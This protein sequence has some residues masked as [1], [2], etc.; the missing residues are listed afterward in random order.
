M[1]DV[2]DTWKE[3]ELLP[4]TDLIKTGDVDIIMSAHVIN[5]ALSQQKGV[6]SSLSRATLMGQLRDTLGFRGVVISDDLQMQAIADHIKFEDAVRRAVLA[7]NDILIFANDKHP[8]PLIPE[9]VAALLNLEAH[10]NPEMLER[11]RKSYRKRQAAEEEALLGPLSAKRRWRQNHGPLRLEIAAA[12]GGTVGKGEVMVL[13]HCRRRIAALVSGTVGAALGAFVTAAAQ[14]GAELFDYPQTALNG[15]VSAQVSVPAEAC[16]QLCSTRSGCAGFDHSSE[17]ICRLFLIVGGATESV[18]HTAGTRSLLANYRP[19]LN[20]PVEP[21]Q[22]SPP[23]AEPAPPTAFMRFANRDLSR[24]ATETRGA[25]SIDQC[26]AMCRYAGGWCKAYTFDTWNEKCFMKEGAGQLEI[27]AR[28]TSGVSS[29]LGTPSLSS[30]EIRFERFNNKA[31]PGDRFRVLS[32]GSR[33]ACEGEC[34]SLN[35]CI[36]YSFTQSQGRC[37]LYEQP[38]EYSS[39]PGT[40]SG[41]KRQD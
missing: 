10:R 27:N 12:I 5:D 6:P 26:E 24:D 41:A 39:R 8:D 36:A 22:P 1:A 35:Q 40:H 9:K 28:A 11:I 32:S 29:S 17:N 38:R 37:V 7:G 4:Y 21:S 33:D 13:Y 2:S 14:S 25:Q 19:P 23:Q 34:W 20:P 15:V 30:E 16:R 3:E 31:F 18:Q